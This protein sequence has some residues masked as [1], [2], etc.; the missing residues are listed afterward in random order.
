MQNKYQEILSVVKKEIE[1][2]VIGLAKNIEVQEP[3][4]SKFCNLLNAPSKH[5]RPLVAFLYLKA[6]G[7][8]IDEKQILYQTAIELVH[9]AS[10]IHDDIIDESL[11]RRGVSTLNAQ[12]GN[13]LSVIS[14]DYLLAVAL[15]NVLKTGNIELI[16]MFSDTLK[17]MCKG[18]IFQHFCKS[19]ISTLEQ[20]LEKSRQKTAKLFET[21]ILGSLKLCNIENLQPALTFAEKFGV[22]FQIRD[23]LI[24]CKTTKTDIQEG[25]YTAPIIFSGNVE[26]IQDGIEKTQILL[27]NYIDEAKISLENIEVNEYKQALIEL[28][29][30]MRDE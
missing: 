18:E 4:N 21:S 10:L 16:Q 29:E 3:L 30:L 7:E 8:I 25:I 2:V 27:N 9:N 15:D 26:N 14:G 17:L 11:E 6:I 5:I 12:F 20:Y 1:L 19:K 23:D 22:A 24:N 28:L 13:K